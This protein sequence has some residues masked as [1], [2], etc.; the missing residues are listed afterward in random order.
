[1]QVSALLFR[2]ERK[3]APTCVVARDPRCSKMTSPPTAG[4]RDGKIR[5]VSCRR[6]ACEQR[7]RNCEGAV[8]AD[9]LASQKR[10]EFRL[11]QERRSITS[12]SPRS[13]GERVGVGGGGGAPASANSEHRCVPRLPLTRIALQSDLSPQA[14]RG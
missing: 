9:T 12:P 6:E 13:S 3:W 10:D 11:R 1:M 2:S 7:L 5:L 14:G 4:S 8:P